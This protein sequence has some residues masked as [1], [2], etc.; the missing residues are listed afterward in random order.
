[1]S[2]TL[3]TPFSASFAIVAAAAIA[4][5]LCTVF[6]TQTVLS[7]QTSSITHPGAYGTRLLTTRETRGQVSC[8][9]TRLS[10]PA[11]DT[12]PRIRGMASLH[13]S[14]QRQEQ[15]FRFAHEDGHDATR[16]TS[17]AGPGER[18]TRYVCLSVVRCRVG[19]TH[20]SSHCKLDVSKCPLFPM[21]VCVSFAEGEN[22]ASTACAIVP[23]CRVIG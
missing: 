8:P 22:T 1:M 15:H 16:G 19:R 7:F 6:C 10:L 17:A 13:A 11:L 3:S 18:G 9:L 14:S 20:V 5:T 2:T 12:R 23:F 4:G 21:R